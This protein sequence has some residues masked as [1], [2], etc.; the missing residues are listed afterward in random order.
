MKI[1]DN[2]L[3][4]SKGSTEMDMVMQN[5]ARTEQEMQQR[6]YSLGQRFFEDH[7][8]DDDPSDRY[9]GMID[10]INKLDQNRKG[11]QK[12]KLRLE[13]KMICENCGAVI[14]YGSI[15][16]SSCG[17]KADEKQVDAN[18]IKCSKCGAEVEAG[19]QFCTSC[20]EK[21]Q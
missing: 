19:S 15:Y 13:G 1:L 18:A 7:K 10:Q 16:C 5:I 8:N 3:N 12:H 9:Y 20:G 6:I 2:I 17:K 21:V 4:T 11:F 14:P